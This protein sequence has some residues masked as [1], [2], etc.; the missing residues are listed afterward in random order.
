VTGAE[1]SWLS[2]RRD[3]K[4]AGT[5]SARGEQRRRDFEA[6]AFAVLRL[7]TNSYLVGAL[8]R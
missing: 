6:S 3:R 7:I 5:S 2:P 8:R 4:P 1:S